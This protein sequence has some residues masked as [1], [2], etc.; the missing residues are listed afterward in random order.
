MSTPACVHNH[1]QC[2]RA[3]RSAF[4][5]LASSWYGKTFEEPGK[6]FGDLAKNWLRDFS[7]LTIGSKRC[8]PL[9]GITFAAFDLAFAARVGVLA[10]LASGGFA[11]CLTVRGASGFPCTLASAALAGWAALGGPAWPLA[12]ALFA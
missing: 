1:R 8:S 2:A 6:S 4:C 12:L 3:H 11:G 10:L 5:L 7:W 9:A